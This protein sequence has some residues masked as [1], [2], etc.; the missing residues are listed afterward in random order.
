MSYHRFRSAV[1]CALALTAGVFSASAQ[2]S[3]LPTN[4]PGRWQLFGRGTAVPGNR[5]LTVAGGYVANPNPLTDC[6]IS[7]RA[8]MA[9]GA[10]QVQ[11]WGVLRAKD[12]LSR[13]VF[14]LR[15]GA[16]PEI[17]LARYAP[18]D[19]S[20]FLG[21]AMLDFVP[22]PTKWYVLRVAVHGK[23][24]QVFLN[25]EKLPRINIEDKD[26]L[27]TEGGFGIGGGWLP[28]EFAD[29]KVSSLTGESLA[30]FTKI[31][32]DVWAPPAVDEEALRA[33]QRA[34]YKPAKIDR[35]PEVR[36]DI[37]LDGNWLFMPD[38]SLAASGSPSSESFSD[39]NWHVIPVPSF[40]TPTI[41]WLHGEYGMPGLKGL[42]ASKGPSDKLSA[43]EY[44][45]CDAQTFDWQHTKAGWYRHHI[46]LPTN[47]AGREFTLVFDAVA[48][49]SDVYVNG[50]NVGG[51]TGMFRRSEYDITKQ[52]KPGANLIAVHVIGQ[53]DKGDD[54]SSKVEAVA[55]TVNVTNEMIRSLPHGMTDNNSGGI[56]QPVKLKVTN[57]VCV[58]SLFIKPRLDGASAEIDIVN[59]SSQSRTVSLA[60]AIRD[61]K[62]QSIFYSGA[63]PVS[64]TVPANGKV[65]AKI[66]T[67][68]LQPKLWSPHEPNLY[69]L[70][71]ALSS[72]GAVIDRDQ[73]RF[74]F[75][76]FTTDGG[77]LMLNGKPYW[78][79]GGN[80]FPVTIRPNDGVLARK[81]I[82]LAKAGNV[83]VTR[84]HGVP[85]TEA[86][87]DAADELGLGV[88]YEGTWPWLMIKG[89]PPPP[90]LLKV[91]KEEFSDLLRQHR[92]HPSILFWT[93][94]NEMN[95]A[96]FDE[97]DVPLLE[98]KWAVLSDMIKTMR[99]IDPTRPIV[100]Y[101]G[102]YRAEAQKSLNQV[103]IPKH[104]DDGDIDDAH[105]YYSWY[106]ESFFH[107]FHGEYG[108]KE[109][110]P[111]RP[112]ITQ[113]LS[114]GYPRNDDWPSRGY[115]FQ[116]YVPQ[117]LVGDFAMEGNDPSI[118]MTRQ[119][120]ITKELAEVIR[121][122]NRDETAGILPFAYLTWFT[123]V[124]KA[125]KIKPKVT[126][127]ELKKAFQPV[128]VSAELTGRHFYA[129]TTASRRVCLVNDSDDQQS[130]PAGK[131]TWEIR[132]GDQVLA[133]GGMDTPVVPYYS[134]K[135]L[136]VDFTMPK[137]LPSPRVDA[138]LVLTLTAGGQTV[139]V[140]DYDLVVATRAWASVAPGT[141]IQVLDPSGRAKATLAGIDATSISS[142]SDAVPSRLLVVGD[143][144]A[145]RGSAV[146]EQLKTYVERGGR[147]LL[148]QPGRDLLKLFPGL[149]KSYR[150]VQGEVV[151]METP[152]SPVFDG[153][154]P[155]DTAWFEMG[156]DNL[157][158][159][160]TGT[161]EV[162]RSNPDVGTLATQCDFHSATP[163]PDTFFKVG[164]A[165]LVSIHIG[166]GQV[167][168][169]E[170]LL[171]V[172]EDDPIAGRLLAN[173]INVLSR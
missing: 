160:C 111:G 139:S 120:F 81:F 27:W 11:I 86:W 151:A 82:E 62:D 121:R 157:P 67:P 58:D 42:A 123:D 56:W 169:S 31:G 103:V 104:Y 54:N 48:K 38:Q 80:H 119:A 6:E 146:A 85:F 152:E 172:K 156:R 53:P 37:S 83:E 100:P 15:G 78:I 87:L 49:V 162:D 45:R 106:N 71:L 20:K 28:T 93:V 5:T 143:A 33:S 2:S 22:D 23:R 163:K 8:R 69:V 122:T 97:K 132:T 73:T 168:A 158:Q 147:V 91:W 88:S 95:F 51:H 92:N 124:W 110:T 68:R 126:Y 14:A 134:N 112:L 135:W 96:R 4:I 61:N 114:T 21:F 154:E 43:E 77:R 108:K 30:A 46:D 115:E 10:D 137:V 170:M 89:E 72:G 17:S 128:L 173:M 63:Q 57:P 164:G 34:A 153:I 12:R 64:V 129:G 94:N 32:D 125:D 60:Y 7:F 138:K 50:T 150:S 18:D 55:V 102:Y 101:S 161:Y 109:F 84:S 145:L 3:G 24:F 141:K 133:Q 79:R 117:T 127:Y 116:R 35:L 44:A 155:L 16:E 118:F 149:V 26:A 25:D 159:A 130:V 65:T 98:R 90:E 142:L 76:T 131:L 39:Q 99:Q 40:W 107:L 41:G 13:Y 59:G 140:N 105:K 74:G 70:D 75:R 136:D 166:K 165:P 171:S 144:S 47:I 66:D 36:G 9:P 148:L 52:L 167:I 1:I 19:G 113:E 29:V